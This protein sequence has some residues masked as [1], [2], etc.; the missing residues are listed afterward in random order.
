M[1]VT[2]N[3]MRLRFPRRAA[4]TAATALSLASLLPQ[5]AGAQLAS[6]YAEC[7]IS[8]GF[9]PLTGQIFLDQGANI[10]G[11]C[12]Q[13]PYSELT[14]S[15]ILQP[16]TGGLLYL[17]SC[18][19]TTAFT[20][21]TS[22][23]LLGPSALQTRLNTDSLF[24]WECTPRPIA[25]P[26]A[27]ATATLLPVPPTPTAVPT[28]ACLN[29][30]NSDLSNLNKQGLD[31]SCGD[32]YHA[33]L[34]GADLTGANLSGANLQQ[35]D[36][37]RTIF[38]QADLTRAVLINATTGGS[39]GPNFSHAHM[40]DI[41]ASFAKLPSSDFRGADLRRA[42]LTHATVA[43]STLQGAD[44]RDARLSQANFTET[45]LTGANLCGAITTGTNFTKAI[46][47]NTGC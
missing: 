46:G 10:V 40:S 21:G 30:R 14:S 18:D 8:P 12:T 42:D 34:V 35:A 15:N 19:N 32:F 1:E 26:A 37:T 2:K 39:P 3:L 13:N 5:G 23:W 44:L 45:D 9:G 31:L 43:G 20:D 22:T 11:D 24:A 28:P 36:V 6:T 7:S 47:L 29:F 41:S 4:V 25:P 33:K 16:T 38:Y 17:R 27:P